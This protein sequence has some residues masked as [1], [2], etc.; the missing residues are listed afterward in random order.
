MKATL[1]TLGVLAIGFGIYFYAFK[2]NAA[3]LTYKQMLDA[4]ANSNVV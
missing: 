2:K 3:G 4:K 1:I